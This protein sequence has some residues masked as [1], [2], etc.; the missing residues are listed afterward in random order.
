M[1]M[2]CVVQA[3]LRHA[4]YASP[5]LMLGR[6]AHMRTARM[7]N[8][9]AAELFGVLLSIAFFCAHMRWPQDLRTP[10]YALILDSDSNMLT[11]IVLHARQAVIG[12]AS[13]L[14]VIS[15]SA[16]TRTR[17]ARCKV[18]SI[19]QHTLVKRHFHGNDELELPRYTPPMYPVVKVHK[20]GLDL[21]RDGW[22]N[23]A[24]LHHIT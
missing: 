9:A 7:G 13:S 2:G 8:C 24:S 17:S 10:P 12:A 11:S 4:S 15:A 22:M 21:L 23:K 5:A 3:L 16:C 1:S 18:L 19:T 20:T 6:S 14:S